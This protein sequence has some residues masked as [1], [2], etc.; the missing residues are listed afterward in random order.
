[1]SRIGIECKLHLVL[2]KSYKFNGG[3]IIAIHPIHPNTISILR[4]NR[5]Q[6][7]AIGLGGILLIEAIAIWNSYKYTLCVLCSHHVGWLMAIYL[8]CGNIVST[9]DT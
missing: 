9:N 1:M 3:L 5:L 2:K 8:L 6:F 4:D 7:N